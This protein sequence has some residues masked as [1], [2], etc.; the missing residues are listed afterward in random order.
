MHDNL[1]ELS[2]DLTVKLGNS[3]W[4]HLAAAH[5]MFLSRALFLTLLLSF[6]PVWLFYVQKWNMS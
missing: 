1:E 4:I 6:F 3:V 5:F 2:Q